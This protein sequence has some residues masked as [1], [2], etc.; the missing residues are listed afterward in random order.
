MPRKATLAWVGRP[1]RPGTNQELIYR[2]QHFCI[3]ICHGGISLYCGRPHSKG[4]VHRERFIGSFDF[5]PC[6]FCGRGSRDVEVRRFRPTKKNRTKYT[7]WQKCSV[8]Y[9]HRM[10]LLIDG[11]KYWA[12]LDPTKHRV[13]I[14]N[15]HLARTPIGSV[16]E[17]MVPLE[18]RKLMK[19]KDRGR[20]KHTRQRNRL[21]ILQVRMPGSAHRVPR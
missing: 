18:I 20:S 16:P 3:T 17:T 1:A 12:K 10:T 4:I 7:D 6:R 14:F 13:L 2:G 15:A 21:D 11:H 8:G 19:E 5:C 9:C